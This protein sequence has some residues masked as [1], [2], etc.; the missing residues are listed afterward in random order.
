MKSVF[1]NLIEDVLTTLFL[2]EW[3]SAETLLHY[4]GL[5]FLKS[6]SSSDSGK[7]LSMDILA[8]VAARLRKVYIVVS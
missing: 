1:D 6:V 3:P 5:L 4:T 7:R 8:L 2:P